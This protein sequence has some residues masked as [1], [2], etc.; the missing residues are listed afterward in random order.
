MKK[1]ACHSQTNQ[2]MKS[3]LLIATLAFAS[4]AS[5][6]ETPKPQSSNGI[7][8]APDAN[9]YAAVPEPSHAMLLML[10]CVGLAARRRR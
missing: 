7:A 3:L 2:N 6:T 4:A 5:A 8:P 10:G 9:L 1:S